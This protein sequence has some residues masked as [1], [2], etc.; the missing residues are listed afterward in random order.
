MYCFAI[1]SVKPT[2][3]KYMNRSVGIRKV[4]KENY[5]QG[6]HRLY[7]KSIA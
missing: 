3:E 6:G 1:C 5:K 7:Y 2:E 4:K